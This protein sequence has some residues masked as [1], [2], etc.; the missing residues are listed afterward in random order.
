MIRREYDDPEVEEYAGEVRWRNRQTNRGCACGN[1]VMPGRCPGRSNCPLAA[2][3]AE[4]DDPV[5]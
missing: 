5:N 3:D 2:I 1:E 4:G